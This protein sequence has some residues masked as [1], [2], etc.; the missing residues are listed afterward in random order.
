MVTS[1]P[2]IWCR[3]IILGSFLL[4]AGLTSVG[5]TPAR[6]FDPANPFGKDG[7]TTV[8]DMTPEQAEEMNAA[9]RQLKM[10]QPL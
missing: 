5:C 7:Y 9:Y 3:T 6:M 2:G 4:I 1:K 10:Q 8:P